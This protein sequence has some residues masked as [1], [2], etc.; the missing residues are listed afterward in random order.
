MF[1]IASVSLPVL[2]ATKKLL[3]VTVLSVGSIVTN[4]EPEVVSGLGLAT[5]TEAVE[6]VAMSDARMAAVS[7]EL[8][9]KVVARGLPF[10]FTTEPATNPAPFTVRVNAGPPGAVASGTNG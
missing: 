2:Q 7:L 10:Q 1:V 3:V 5:V 8:L 9:T 4:P 6:A